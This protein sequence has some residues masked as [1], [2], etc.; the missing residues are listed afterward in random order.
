MSSRGA[1]LS[2]RGASFSWARDLAPGA[3]DLAPGGRDLAPGG[4]DLVPGA[5]DLA[6][7]SP[8]PSS[9][10]SRI[11]SPHSS[12]ASRRPPYALDCPAIVRQLSGKRASP[13]ALY[14]YIWAWS[15]REAGNLPEICL[16]QHLAG[17]ACLSRDS[18]RAARPCS[19]PPAGSR[20]ASVVQ[21]SASDPPHWGRGR[22]HYGVIMGTWARQAA[23]ARGRPMQH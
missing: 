6:P 18:L 4:R 11:S 13:A 9:S 20:G 14:T 1:S 3:R 19:G 22:C 10:A 16:R 5:R 23:R 17:G 8:P 15:S 12:L 7:V 21:R 2:S